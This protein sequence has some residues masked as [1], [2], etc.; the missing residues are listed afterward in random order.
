MKLVWCNGFQEIYAQL[1]EE[2]WGLICHGN[3]YIVPYMK[4]IWCNDF[5]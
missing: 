1:E 3:M 2:G 4:L 5:P